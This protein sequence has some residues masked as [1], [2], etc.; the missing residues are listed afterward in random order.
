MYTV[1]AIRECESAAMAKIPC[2]YC[3]Q[4]LGMFGKKQSHILSK[5]LYTQLKALGY[6]HGQYKVKWDDQ[7]NIV[8][9]CKNCLKEIGSDMLVPDWSSNGAFAYFEEDELHDYA[10]FFYQLSFPL[11]HMFHEAIPA[12]GAEESMVAVEAF[13]NE[14]EWRKKNDCWDIGMPFVEERSYDSYK[15]SAMESRYWWEPR[16]A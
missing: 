3:N 4:M 12:P 13:R 2:A 10:D 11:M 16:K 9:C 1:S 5:S 15:K 7:R 6:L 14:Y 8:I